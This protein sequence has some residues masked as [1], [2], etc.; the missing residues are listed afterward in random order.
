MNEMKWMNQGSQLFLFHFTQHTCVFVWSAEHNFMPLRFVYLQP[1]PIFMPPH[2]TWAHLS[3][4]LWILKHSTIIG[5]HRWV[6]GRTFPQPD[7]CTYQNAI[8][9]KWLGCDKN[10]SQLGWQVFHFFCCKDIWRLLGCLAARYSNKSC[11]A[12]FQAAPGDA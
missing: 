3:A 10:V 1:T 7:T 5:L 6:T 8:N 12:Q 4:C 9:W 2:L 11:N